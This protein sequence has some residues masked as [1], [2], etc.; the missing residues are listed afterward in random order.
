MYI[1]GHGGVSH[2]KM[3]SLWPWS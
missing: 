3:R 2:I 1:L